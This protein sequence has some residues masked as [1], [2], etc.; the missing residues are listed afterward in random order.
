[1]IYEEKYMAR[2]LQ[3]ARLG[4][5]YAMPNPMVGA[6][7]VDADGK[8]IGEGYHRKCGEPHAEVN[9]INSVTDPSS[10]KD[11]TIYVTL[12]PCAHYGRT[13]PCAKLI[14]EKNIPRVVVGSRD[15]FEKVDG[16][17]IEMLKEAG[18]DVKVGM[19]EKE[20]R[21]LNAI[22]FTA[23]TLH[24]PF[25]LLKWAQS[26]DGYIDT[27]HTQEQGGTKISTMLTSMLV[28]RWRSVCDGILIGSN[29][30][31][32]DNP[33]LD[34]RLWPGKSPRPI[35]LDRRGRI[36]ADARIFERNP[37]I[38]N[39]HAPLPETLVQLYQQGFTSIMV[40]GG[41]EVLQSFI[42]EG[43]WD[44]ARIETSPCP[45]GDT[46]SVRAPHFNGILPV[47]TYELE[48]NKIEYYTK[49]TLIDVK[50]I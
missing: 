6:V 49:N 24:R 23:H 22:F 14:I 8:I 31:I 10:L 32:A 37:L 35:I 12:E 21:Q 50:N 43:L 26:A 40:E 47:K 39:S 18:V 45:F 4:F 38:I 20:C 33:M 34:T 48:G 1:M 25:I 11:C 41:K 7:I 15:P 46:G 42:N 2:A 36:P 30:V 16:K 13:G 17:G 44:I 5:P 19:L 28:H 27:K 3:I 9:A 29:T